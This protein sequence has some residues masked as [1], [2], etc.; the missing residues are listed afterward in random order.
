MSILKKYVFSGKLLM[1]SQAD[2][3]VNVFNLVLF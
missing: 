3:K 1:D 2:W